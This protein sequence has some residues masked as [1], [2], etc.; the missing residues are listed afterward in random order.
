MAF[1]SFVSNRFVLL[2]VSLVHVRQ[3]FLVIGLKWTGRSLK[4][5][6]FFQRLFVQMV[7]SCHAIDKMEYELM[8]TS[9]AF[10]HLRFFFFFLMNLADQ[11]LNLS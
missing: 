9:S 10:S 8:Y 4:A 6:V 11:S 7:S 3:F 5:W 2:H 1:A